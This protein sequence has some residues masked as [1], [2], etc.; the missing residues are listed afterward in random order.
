M[1]IVHVDIEMSMRHLW[2]MLDGLREGAQERQ[3]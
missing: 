1:N 3:G 2:K